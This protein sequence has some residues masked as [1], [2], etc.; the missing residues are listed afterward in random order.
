MESTIASINLGNYVDYNYSSG[1]LTSHTL[2]GQ[3][4]S[5]KL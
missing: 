3:S 4:P 2:S 5:I 1:N